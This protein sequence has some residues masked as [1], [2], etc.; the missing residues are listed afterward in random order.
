[1]IPKL[2]DNDQTGFIKGRF[3]GEN[4]LLIDSIIKYASSKNIPG[5]LL[6]V[7][8]EKAFDSVDWTF[9]IRTLEN[10]GFGTSFIH[11]IKLFYTDIESCVLNNGWASHTFKLQRG[12]RQGCPLSPYL[13]ILSA[14]IL[15]KAVRKNNIIKGICVNNQEIKLSQYADDTTFILDGTKESLTATFHLLESFSLSSGLR[16]NYKKPE[17]LWIGSCVGKEENLLPE[18]KY[19]MERK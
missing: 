3:I 18:K 9:I 11:G 17:A 8:F 10:F 16:I 1:M 2:I 14:E 15:A 5:L 12:V 7:D 13:F 6:F 4:I 19:P